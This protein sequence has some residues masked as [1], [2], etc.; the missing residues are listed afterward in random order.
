MAVK[1]TWE[2]TVDDVPRATVEF[3]DVEIDAEAAIAAE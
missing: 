3:L 1:I 2:H